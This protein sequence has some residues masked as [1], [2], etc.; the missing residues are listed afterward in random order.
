M[1]NKDDNLLLNEKNQTILQSI[2]Q[3]QDTEKFMFKSLKAIE[4]SS[5]KEEQQE[6]LDNINNLTNTRISLFNKIND[7]YVNVQNNVYDDRKA[8]SNQFAL[9]SMVENELNRLKTNV[10]QKLDNKTNTTRLI[11]IDEYQYDKYQAH[12]YIMKI[13]ALMGLVLL[14]ISVVHKRKLL[15]SYITTGLA[16]ITL[17]ISIIYL[18]NYINDINNRDIND[19]N[20]YNF[21]VDQQELQNNYQTVLE[22]DESQLKNFGSD[23]ERNMDIE[24]GK[25][26][27]SNM[28]SGLYKKSQ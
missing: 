4:E 17:L 8:L 21:D 7:Q 26:R 27:Y 5:T 3:L 20:K 18:V 13:I 6:I 23:I 1:S 16:V 9:V 10:K 25:K 28:I 12:T 22:F 19:F 14:I 2:Q 24:N 11:E 15:P